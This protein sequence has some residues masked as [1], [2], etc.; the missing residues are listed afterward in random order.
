MPFLDAA[1]DDAMFVYVH[2]DPAGSLA[3]SLAI[4]RSGD[5][6]T[7]PQLP[8][9][10]GP[11]WSFLLVP[12]WEELRGRDLAEVI[13]EQWVRTVGRL[14]DDLEALPAEQWCVTEHEALRADPAGELER[15]FGFLGLTWDAE[16]VLDERFDGPRAL[17]P[18][19]Q[20]A[21]LDE[22]SP[23]LPRTDALAA[24][25]ADWIAPRAGA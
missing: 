20:E 16:Q 5:A 17:R 24:R 2:R 25:A 8:G 9:W 4:W 7:Y 19:A 13:V 18:D 1:F 23:Y 15:L 10:S 6:V 22:L 21:L 14:L 12:G 3:E 11:P